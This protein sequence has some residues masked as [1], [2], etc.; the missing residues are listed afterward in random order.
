[1]SAGKGVLA[2]VGAVVAMLALGLIAGGGGLLWAYGNDRTPD[3][4]FTSPEV[5]LATD[6]FALISTDIDLGSRPGDWYPDGRLATVRLDVSA[7]GDSPVFVGI[8]PEA[9]VDRYLQGVGISEVTAVRADAVTYRDTVG[10]P[11]AAPPSQQGFWV[12]SAEGPAGQSLTWELERGVW[13]VVIM[14]A[15]GSAGVSVDMAAGASTDLLIPVALGLLAAGAVFGTLA[16]L[17]LFVAVR[18][19]TGDPKVT[20]VPTVGGYGVYPVRVEGR[21]ATDLSRWQWLV[22]WLLVIPHLVVLAF[23]WAAFFVLTVVAGFAILFTGRYPRAI[24]D[25][26]VGVMRWTWRVA[27]YSYGALAS[28]QYPPFTLAE[29]DYPATLDVAYPQELS[30]GLVLVKWW[31]LAIPHYLI[32]G[33]FTS[34]L[35][36]WTTGIGDTGNAAFQLGGGLIG[37]LV[38]IA[39][40][41]VAFS[42]RYPQSLFDLVM[43]LNRWVYRVLAYAALMRD[44][45][46][47]F[48]LDLGGSEPDSAPPTPPTDSPAGDDSTTARETTSA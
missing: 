30:R 45:Y 36:S 17:L 39:G 1:M 35:I 14:N 25:F 16:A 44:E 31:L 46:P 42:G 15:D 29:S 7:T 9:D 32:V 41:V 33:L 21:L 38:L 18:R 43:G 6:Q 13:A 47:P 4:F 20:T 26:N 3:G 5:A 22:K 12:A 37:L 10:G 48:R 2:A 34:G 8:G 23:L 40:V 27:Y 19:P 11:P 28:D 24:F